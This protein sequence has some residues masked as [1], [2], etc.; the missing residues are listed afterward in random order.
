MAK[1]QKSHRQRLAIEASA[2]N[3]DP[4]KAFPG[5]VR[6]TEDVPA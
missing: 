4:G 3:N 6:K 1:Y 2:T 5:M